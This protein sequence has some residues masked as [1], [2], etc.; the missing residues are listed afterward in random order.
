MAAAKKFRS[1]STRKIFKKEELKSEIL[2]LVHFTTSWNGASQIVSIIY[3]DLAE[4]F[5]GAA[6]FYTVD[7]EKESALGKEYGIMEVPTI[8]FFKN[9]QLVDHAVGLVSR[10]LLITK[11]ENALQISDNDS[12]AL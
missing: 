5:N 10:S 4:I 7:F 11:I 2:I 8:L 1:M 3:D 12:K 6:K 9:G